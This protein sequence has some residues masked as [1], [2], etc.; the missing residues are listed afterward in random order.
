MLKEVIDKIK[1]WQNTDRIGPDILGTYWRLFFKSK[2]LKL[3]K[4]KFKHFADDADFRPGAYAIGCSQISIGRRVVIRPGTML[5]GETDTLKDSILI[6]DDVLVGCGVH[7]YVENHE[8]TKLD[9]PIIDQG[10]TQARKVIL[11]K[12]CWIGANVIIL[13]GVIIGENTVIGAGAVVTKSIPDF[14][15]AVG[16][17]AR[18]I[19]SIKDQY[20]I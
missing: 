12:G 14:S 2:M 6:E 8:F 11:K 9:L 7:I 10:H 16:N 17:P 4:K 18:V 20:E 19:K 13:P 15:I 1:F 5:H 3:C